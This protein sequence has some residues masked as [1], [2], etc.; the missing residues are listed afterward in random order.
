VPVGAGTVSLTAVQIDDNL[1]VP[2]PDDIDVVRFMDNR[3][4]PVRIQ[5]V[6]SIM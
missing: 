3:H 1:I 6:A 5:D 2:L 4:Q